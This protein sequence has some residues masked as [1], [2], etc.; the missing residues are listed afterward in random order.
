MA[1]TA[2]AVAA[3][4]ALRVKEAPV[5]LSLGLKSPNSDW[6][7]RVAERVDRWS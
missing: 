6:V 5:E 2:M 1:L 4:D 3:H 7:S